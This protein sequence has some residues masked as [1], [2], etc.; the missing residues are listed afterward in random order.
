MVGQ[1][2]DEYYREWSEYFSKRKDEEMKDNKDL[3]ER[4]RIMQEEFEVKVD[5]IANGYL[6][7]DWSDDVYTK[8]YCANL[9]EVKEKIGEIEK[10]VRAASTQAAH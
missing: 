1:A 5:G 7:T 3:E 8:Y 9:Q 2:W 4:Y 10:Q 6:V